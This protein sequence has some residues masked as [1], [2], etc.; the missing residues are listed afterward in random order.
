MLNIRNPK[1]DR[2]SI[3]DPSSYYEPV[4]PN[5]M[6]KRNVVPSNQRK[7]VNLI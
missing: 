1:L 6:K 5:N 3:W 4:G 7:T 2:I